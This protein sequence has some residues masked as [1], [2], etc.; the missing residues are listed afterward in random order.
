MSRSAPERWP[1]SSRRGGE[2]GNLDAL[3]D[4][5]AHPLGG[6]REAADRLGDG[7]GQEHREQDGHQRHEAEGE[8]HDVA[9]G[10]QHVVDFAAGRGQHQGAEHGAEALHRHRRP[11][12]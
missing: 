2:V 3:V 4:A 6:G 12:R 5:A 7:A 8:E 9:L 11:E 1:I 10:A